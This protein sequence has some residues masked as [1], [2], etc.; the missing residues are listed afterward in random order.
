M[1][2]II[3]GDCR[4]ALKAIP[5]ESV[6]C[7]ITSPPYW[8]L[9]DYGVENQIGM[10][11]TFQHYL[12]NLWGVFDQIYRVL[13]P[14][15]SVW[16]V[17]GDC[18]S[19]S[20]QKKGIIDPKVS[21]MDGV[22]YVHEGHTA[23]RLPRK[24]LLQLPARFGIGMVDRGWI[25]RN[26]I[27][28]HKPNVMPQSVKDRFTI[29]FETVM[30]FTKAERYYFKQQKEP[31]QAKEESSIKAYLKGGKIRG[32]RGNGKPQSGRRKQ[33]QTG[34]QTYTGFNE[35]CVPPD[36][37]M[38]NKRCVWVVNASPEQGIE[39]FAM[40]PPELIR[41]M[42]DAGCPDGGTV[43]D[44]FSGSGTTGIVAK[45]QNKNYIGIELNEEYA[46]NSET[47]IERKTVQTTMF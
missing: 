17:M 38:R 41:P 36:D 46:E 26:E 7:V 21:Y 16:V 27:I 37:G 24:C 10:E 42:M 32:S 25:L 45:E 23:N 6:D 34:N 4:E 18:Y 13:R 15:G 9:R 8:R 47:R 22:G 35:R 19:F 12:E 30:F 40:F 31:F 28:W 1:Y 5:D 20:G 2:Q 14:H 11:D 3:N 44:P 29:N 39:H 33:D 43:L